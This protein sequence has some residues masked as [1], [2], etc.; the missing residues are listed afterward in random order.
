[1]PSLKFCF[2][3]GG[4]QNR[5]F[6]KRYYELHKLELNVYFVK[7]LLSQMLGH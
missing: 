3:A 7:L 6:L 2:H 1:M 5:L 4:F